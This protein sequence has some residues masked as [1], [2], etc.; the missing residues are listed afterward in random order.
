MLK[1][2]RPDGFLKRYIAN[3]VISHFW[4]F[5]FWDDFFSFTKKKGFLGFLCPPYRGI[6]ATIRI[7]QEMLC[8][9]GQSGGIGTMRN[10][11]TL[12]K[13]SYETTS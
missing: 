13:Y 11:G 2:K 10:G 8:L 5:D 4:V 7:G 9:P 12:N 3:F 6:G 1:T